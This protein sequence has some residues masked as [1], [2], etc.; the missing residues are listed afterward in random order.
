MSTDVRRPRRQERQS[1]EK[2]RPLTSKEKLKL[3]LKKLGQEVV[4]NIPD[5]SPGKCVQPPRQTD[6]Y[7]CE[8]YL[9]C[10]ELQEWF[11]L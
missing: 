10:F 8:E 9:C 2:G 1:R 3:K 5:R 6:H 7:R 4:S 11:V